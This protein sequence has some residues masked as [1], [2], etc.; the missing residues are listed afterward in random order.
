[1]QH[2]NIA[3][4]FS[5]FKFLTGTH[6]STY[7]FINR[8][9]IKRSIA[10]LVIQN[11]DNMFKLSIWSSLSNF[12][13]FWAVKSVV[14]VPVV[15]NVY[16][17]LEMLSGAQC[18]CVEVVSERVMCIWLPFSKTNWKIS[19]ITMM[20]IWCISLI[21]RQEGY[22]WVPVSI[23]RQLPRFRS[24]NITYQQIMVGYTINDETCVVVWIT[25][26]LL[27]RPK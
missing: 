27:L 3:V 5:S 14:L 13:D 24:G 11:K 2:D 23:H 21:S 6:I 10:S 15:F 8:L 19:F 17:G 9:I 20:V 26:T 1:M 16:V 22:F 7:M 18:V 4:P 25:P 12:C